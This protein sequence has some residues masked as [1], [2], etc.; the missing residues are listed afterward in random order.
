MLGGAVG[1]VVGAFAIVL[2]V[3][4]IRLAF[5]VWIHPLEEDFHVDRAALSLV[6]ALGYLTFGLIQPFLGRIVD[7]YG[8][9][10]VLPGAVL[11]SGIGLCASSLT[12]SYWAFLAVYSLLASVGFAGLANATLAAAVTQ[13]FTSRRGLAFGAISAGGPFGQLVMAPLAAIGVEVVGWR[14]TMGALGVVLLAVALPLAWLVLGRTA[15]PARAA[16]ASTGVL[17][18]YA[19]ALKNRGFQLLFAAYFI[20]G[21]TTL[22]LVHT[23]IV[24]YGIDL[25]LP[26]VNA[27]RVLG[28]IGLCNGFGLI[29]WGHLADRWGGRTPLIYVFAVRSVALLWVSTASTEA[30]LLTFALIFGMTDMATIPLSANAAAA[31]LGPR[32]IGVT[33]GLLAVAHQMGS[34]VGSYLAGYGF[35]EL[36]G[37]P[38]IIIAAAGVALLGSLCCIAL[39]IGRYR[40]VETGGSAGLA[41]S[42]AAS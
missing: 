18:V 2:F 15:P 23:H 36:H 29:A 3:G 6:A 42:G 12:S 32:V 19:A 9:R 22:G 8:S 38:P 5:G 25:G 34:A 37:Y 24:P 7:V 21:V 27:A 39:D 28:L 1:M 14:S 30:N 35:R 16:G 26:D 13:R 31:L 4:G 11:L 33:V 10:L 20:C 40:V 41:P 17:A